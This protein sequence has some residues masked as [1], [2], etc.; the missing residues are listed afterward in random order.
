MTNGTRGKVDLHLL[1][2]VN[3][4]LSYNNCHQGLSCRASDAER[5]HCHADACTHMCGGSTS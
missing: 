4:P 2:G 5:R 3:K 1:Q